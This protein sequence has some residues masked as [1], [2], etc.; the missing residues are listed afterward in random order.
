M[1]V[2]GK[3]ALIDLHCHLLP[4]IDDGPAT[5]DDALALARL[6]VAQGI[7][8]AACTPHILP[9]VY[10]NTGPQIRAAVARLQSAL[11]GAGIPLRLVTGADLHMAPGN[12]A[13]LKSGQ[14]LCL[15]D[16][17]FV[18]IEPPHHVLPPRI[19]NAFFD[20]A[21]AGFTALLTHPERMSWIERNYDVL[22]RLSAANVLMQ[23]TAGAF[24]GAFGR[25]PRY[26]AERMLDDGLADVVATD[27]HDATRRPPLLADAYEAV[28]RRAGPDHAHGLFI[29]TPRAILE[30]RPP[31]R[32]W[33]HEKRAP[34]PDGF[35]SSRT[36][37]R[38]GVEWMQRP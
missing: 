10:N 1:I 12:A 38:A 32:P 30:N 20:L 5:L 9:G 4:G 7:T 19:E 17:R 15:A 6:A 23:I 21:A 25:R 34:V 24:T 18:L 27:A 2:R 22:K 29:E 11:D 36:W 13:A 33:R 31:A 3:G 35:W 26:W 16:T 28:S 8:T 37:L 14:A